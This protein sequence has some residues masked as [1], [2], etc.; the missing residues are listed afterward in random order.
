MKRDFEYLTREIEFE[1]KN[2]IPIQEIAKLAFNYNAETV[3]I[4]FKKWVNNIYDRC[5]WYTFE[6]NIFKP[7]KHECLIYIDRS[8]N[9]GMNFKI[10]GYG[11]DNI[12]MPVHNQVKIFRLL[13]KLEF[14]ALT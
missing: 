5:A 1:G 14:I 6:T 11:K 10:D 9:I 12:G 4:N 3:E 2:I 7:K 8:F 13:Q